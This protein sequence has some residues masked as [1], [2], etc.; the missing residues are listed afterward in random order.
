M[1]PEARQELIDAREAGN[2]WD[3]L[4][5]NYQFLESMEM[6]EQL[7]H[8]KDL[9]FV[10]SLSIKNT[11]QDVKVLEDDLVKYQIQGPDLNR[12]P[13]NWSGNPEILRDEYI[14][15]STLVF[16]QANIGNLLS[17]IRTSV[18]NDGLRRMFIDQ[19]FKTQE[20]AETLVKYLKLKGWLENTPV[21]LN[22][23][24][25]N[26][27]KLCTSTASQLWGHVTFRYDSVRKTRLFLAVAHDPDFK[28]LLNL[29][30]RILNKQVST[31][32][33]ECQHFGITLPKRP[34]HAMVTPF[35]GEVINDDQLY[36]DVLLGLQGAATLHTDANK[37]CMINDRI[38]ILF[39]DMLL[40]EIEFYDKFIKYGKLKGWLHPVPA[41][42]I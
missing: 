22:T 42:Q 9:K 12:L 40:D 5:A 27:E 26:K 29:G 19:L 20:R 39:T 34:P 4:Q 25:E 38:R 33:A 36:R 11:K 24:P 7:A 21:Y 1:K 31:L 17:A 41:Y 23:P 3:I 35:T 8:D 28:V 14:G 16:L 10:L 6:Y 18:T 37:K 32:E 2:L 13:S 15:S 30:L